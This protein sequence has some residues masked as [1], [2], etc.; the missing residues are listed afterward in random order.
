[1]TLEHRSQPRSSYREPLDG[2]S[3]LI[4]AALVADALIRPHPPW[5]W[6]AAPAYLA[7]V[8]LLARARTWIVAPLAVAGVL[9][10]LAFGNGGPRSIAS[11][12]VQAGVLIAV[13]LVRR[14]TR[15]HYRTELADLD[16][17]GAH[18]R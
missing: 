16:D 5:A 7:A 11:A 4:A 9:L 1:M 8:A 18:R 15:M 10:P 17:A 2:A 14:R 3:L 13:M 6:I 12:A